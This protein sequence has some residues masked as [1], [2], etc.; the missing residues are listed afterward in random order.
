MENKSKMHFLG[1]EEE[2]CVT[3]CRSS[4]RCSSQAASREEGERGWGLSTGE[5]PGAK[6]AH[7]GHR[8]VTL[9]EGESSGKKESHLG[10][11]EVTWGEG[12]SPGT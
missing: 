10:R 11:G 8:R 12:E 3:P 4:M 9:G 6:E 5:S 1:I 2:L 7:L